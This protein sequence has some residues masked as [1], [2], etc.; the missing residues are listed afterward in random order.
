S[1]I[2][3]TNGEDVFGS[4]YTSRTTNEYD[5][6]ASQAKRVSSDTNTVS[7][8]IFGGTVVTDSHVDYLY[9]ELGN[10]TEKG[11][12]GYTT[13]TSINIFG[14]NSSTS[15]TNEYEIINGQPKLKYSQ[16]GPDLVNPSGEAGSILKEVESAL[17]GLVGAPEEKAQELAKKTGVEIAPEVKKNITLEYIK[18]IMD[19]FWK[20]STNVINCAVNVLRN[21]FKEK[22]IDINEGNIAK[23][24][25]L[26]D[27]LSGVITPE[28]A[29]GELKLS[30]YAILKSA[31]KQGVNL[32]AGNITIEQLKEINLPAVVRI[33]RNHFVLIKGID[34]DKVTYLDNGVETV[35]AISD[36]KY[37]WDGNVLTA[38]LPQA[39]AELTLK[40]MLEIRGSDQDPLTIYDTS[41][42]IK[43]SKGNDIKPGKS[44]EILD[45]FTS[46]GK[47]KLGT[48]KW[49]NNYTWNDSIWVGGFSIEWNYTNPLNSGDTKHV[50]KTWQYGENAPT[51]PYP[52]PTKTKPADK[53]PGT[54]RDSTSPLD[55]ISH[56]PDWTDTEHWKDNS[57]WV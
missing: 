7:E 10:F 39:V 45:Y 9:D 34:S 23:D 3:S 36:F 18:T 41:P 13:T 53:D 19:W 46:D 25:I 33:N 31:E 43:D 21:I 47:T 20:A 52:D 24:A 22:A 6:I 2:S 35:K 15:T 54:Y 17:T 40:E 28:N 51:E 30:F 27:V 56:T 4:K 55:P 5:I 44:S 38:Q 32:R 50:T 49:T 48:C 26:V 37:E 14:E 12:K 57:Q 29:K 42:T 11:A 1:E 16:T 8:N